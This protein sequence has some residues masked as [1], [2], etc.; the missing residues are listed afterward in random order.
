[1]PRPSRG[2]IIEHATRDGCVTRTLRFSVNGKKQ[3]VAL[4]VVSREEA[5][6]QLAYTIADVERGTWKPSAPPPEH[7]NPHSGGAGR[8]WRAGPQGAA[9]TQTHQAPRHAGGAGVRR[10][11]HRRAARPAV[12]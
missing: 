5:E 8:G 4:G 12:A 9:R 11:A 2:T 1:M 6:R 3:R 7:R 10:G